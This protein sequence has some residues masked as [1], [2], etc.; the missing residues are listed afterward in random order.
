MTLIQNEVI[1]ALEAM[2]KRNQFTD[3]QL[4]KKLREIA[5]IDGKS[6][7]LIALADLTASIE[8]LAESGKYFR[9]L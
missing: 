2:G 4:A 6:R 3:A 7:S 9:L 5:N 8:S 1:K